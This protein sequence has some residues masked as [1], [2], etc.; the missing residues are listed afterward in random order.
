MLDR[1]RSK[2]KARERARRVSDKLGFSSAVPAERMIDVPTRP[3]DSSSSAVSAVLI[4]P[5]RGNTG[6]AASPA[7]ERSS[8]LFL[9]SAD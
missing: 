8:P 5:Y 1:L 9:E 4:G 2:L 7:T 3:S 6:R